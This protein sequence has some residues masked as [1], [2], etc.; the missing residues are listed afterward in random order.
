MLIKKGLLSQ[1]KL[2]MSMKKSCL[3]TWQHARD[4]IVLRSEQQQANSFKSK[5]CCE[6]CVLN[7]QVKALTS[8]LESCEEQRVK[9]SRQIET[10]METMR[11]KDVRNVF[12]MMPSKMTR[13]LVLDVV[14]VYAPEESVSH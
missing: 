12:F 2:V 14:P 6:T 9:C 8:Q 10:M 11:Q 4:E 5:R 3:C 7:T 13:L 1:N